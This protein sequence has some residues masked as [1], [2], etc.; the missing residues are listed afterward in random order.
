MKSFKEMGI[1]VTAPNFTGDKIKIDRILNREISVLD[2]K[3]GPSTQK[4]GTDCL[5]LQ[6]EVNDQKHIIFTGAKALIQ[7][8]QQVDR[9]DLPFKTTIIKDNETLQFS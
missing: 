8:I 5:T 9:S 6:I 4:V 7:M 1:K 2:F 3:I